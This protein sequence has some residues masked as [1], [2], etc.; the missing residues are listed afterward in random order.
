MVLDTALGYVQYRYQ[1][2]GSLAKAGMQ[3]RQSLDESGNVS[4]F[5]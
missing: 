1:L 2:S 4:A 3:V 5:S